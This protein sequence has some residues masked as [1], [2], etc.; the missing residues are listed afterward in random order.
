MRT[1]VLTK[2]SLILVAASVFAPLYICSMF[3]QK[4]PVFTQ[5]SPM[6][7]PKSAYQALPD[8]RGRKHHC[9]PIQLPNISSKE[10]CIYTK[11]PCASA[12]KCPPSFSGRSWLQVRLLPYTFAIYFL[13]SPIF[14]Q[15]SPMHPRKISL[16]ARW[17][18]RGRVPPKAVSLLILVAAITFASLYIRKRALPIRKRALYFHERALC[19]CKR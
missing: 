12:K 6:N 4:S 19:I 14:T 16:S 10:P 11:E 3:L 8:P 5:R 13:K 9:T 1:R 2:L 7:P 18:M 17:L 15:K